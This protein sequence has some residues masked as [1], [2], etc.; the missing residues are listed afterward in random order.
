MNH[1]VNGNLSGLKP[2][3]LKRLEKLYERRTSPSS[4]ISDEFA[5]ALCSISREIGRQIGTLIDRRGRVF[6]IFV[7]DSSSVEIS[8]FGRYRAGR[9]RLRGLR[10]I[11]TH[12]NDAPLNNDDLTDLSLLRFDLIAAIESSKEGYPASLY[13]AHL[14]P[15]EM[16]KELYETMPKMNFYDFDIDVQMFITDLEQEMDSAE[17]VK[18]RD[19]SDRRAILV[20][21]TT[22]DLQAAN[23]SMDE[24]EA[25]ALS[26]DIQVLD[27]IV[28]KRRSID[29]A[30]VM[31]KGKLKELFIKS[32]QLDADLIVFDTELSG[33]QMRAVSDVAEIEVI[34]RTQLILD[35][36]A[37]RAFSREG[38]IQVELAQMRYSLPRFV[39][40]D[41]FLSRITGGIRSKG[42]GE[43]KMEILKRRVR[44]RIVSLEKELKSIVKARDERRKR[45]SRNGLPIVSVVGYTNAGKSTLLNALSS[46]DLLESSKLFATL[47][48]VGRRVPLPDGK[49]HV[50]FTDTV[51]FIRNIPEELLAAFR[52]TLEEMQ[53]S[54]LLLH[55]VD[56]S[57][58][59]YREHIEAV[60]SI[61]TELALD[62]IPLL[63]V[64]S[65]ADL[66]PQERREELAEETGALLISSREPESLESLLKNISEI[67]EN[68]CNG[69]GFYS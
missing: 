43:T 5:K 17:V 36:F 8:D 34:D 51:G 68:S 47:D 46:S 41:D 53:D 29:T 45:R 35:I 69:N 58:P 20:H 4:L 7:G 56:L 6:G 52:A 32:L 40:K 44:D 50:I 65:K 1:K 62:N 25:L 64:G 2:A 19:A 11:H 31:G 13:V 37:R 55:L 27:K 59:S 57:S 3:Q 38:K 63:L 15:Y 26:A 9:G 16:G 14:L 10:F 49:G 21:V 54:H 23:E 33:S 18:T 12:L 28:Q 48:T 61:L 67:L 30:Y 24:L 39:M 60:E 22:G 66:I 42:P